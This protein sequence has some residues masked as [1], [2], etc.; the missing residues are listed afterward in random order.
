[1]A[2]D[3]PQ[4]QIKDKK[5]QTSVTAVIILVD[6]SSQPAHL[7]VQFSSLACVLLLHTLGC[8]GRKSLPAAMLLVFLY[9]DSFG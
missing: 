5:P 3:S 4:H 2:C 8:A 1:M 6:F 7:R 9:M